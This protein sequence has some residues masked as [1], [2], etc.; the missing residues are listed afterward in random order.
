[1]GE[2]EKIF[3]WYVAEDVQEALLGLDCLQLFKARIDT[4]GLTIELEDEVVPVVSKN[5]VSLMEKKIAPTYTYPVREIIVPARHQ[6]L[7]ELSGA[8]RD[9]YCVVSTLDLPDG[10]IAAHSL[11]DG[12]FPVARVINVSEEDITLERNRRFIV[13]EIEGVQD[14][15]TLG[16]PEEVELP[17]CEGEG[18]TSEQQRGLESLIYQFKDVFEHSKQ[19]QDITNMGQHAIN[20]GNHPPIKKHA[21]RKNPAVRLREKELIDGMLDKGVIVPSKSPWCAPALLVKKKDGRNCSILRRL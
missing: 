10:L 2:R 8:D 4:A 15:A 1:M 5:P 9:D 13:D 19:K 17:N 6:Q 14:Q 16:N 12:Q 18:L 21:Y 7:V 11:C 20:T 3:V